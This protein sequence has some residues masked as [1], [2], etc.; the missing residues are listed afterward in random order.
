MTRIRVPIALSICSVGFRSL[1]H[2]TDR[3][4]HQA[5][6]NACDF[7]PQKDFLQ[8][9][10]RCDVW[11]YSPLRKSSHTL[12]RFL[13][14][15]ATQVVSKLHLSWHLV[16]HSCGWM[17]FSNFIGPRLLPS[18]S[19]QHPILTGMSGVGVGTGVGAGVGGTLHAPEDQ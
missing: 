15:N 16:S 19:R 2:G 3:P 4:R 7:E 8:S 5:A 6:L 13:Y 14:S 18:A 10:E 17:F 12:D 11:S 1:V 9:F